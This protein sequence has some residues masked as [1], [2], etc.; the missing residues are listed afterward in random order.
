MGEEIAKTHNMKF[1]ETSARTGDGIKDAFENI[2][3]EI[4]KG[5]DEKSA[6]KASETGNQLAQNGPGPQIKQFNLKKENGAKEKKK[7]CAC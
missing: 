5:L 1:Y 2:S 3:R 7:G 6:K 4:I